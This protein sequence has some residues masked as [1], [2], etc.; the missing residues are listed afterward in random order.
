[1]EFSCLI[2]LLFL[3]KSASPGKRR[4][5]WLLSGRGK[6]ILAVSRFV[7]CLKIWGICGQR[8]LFAVL[9]CSLPVNYAEEFPCDVLFVCASFEKWVK[10]MFWIS[11]SLTERKSEWVMDLCELL[12]CDSRHELLLMYMWRVIVES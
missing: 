12:N 1:M 10:E 5:K 7:G 9:T 8:D 4:I 2:C 3:E 11:V 6:K